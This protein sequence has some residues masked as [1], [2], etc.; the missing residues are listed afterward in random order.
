[1]CVVRCVLF[2]VCCCAL[3]DIRCLLCG[4]RRGCGLLFVVVASWC[5][6]SV[7][8]PVGVRCYCFVDCCC[9]LILVAVAGVRWLLFVDCCL[10]CVV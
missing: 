6:C 1:M 3:C 2:L 9:V 7:G 5:C 4:D 10:L 8:L